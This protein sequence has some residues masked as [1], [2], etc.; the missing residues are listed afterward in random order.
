MDWKNEGKKCSRFIIIYE[1]VNWTTVKVTVLFLLFFVCF[2]YFVR[3]KRYW[4]KMNLIARRFWRMR[5]FSKFGITD[6]KLFLR[7]RFSFFFRSFF[8][9][10][11]NSDTS[12][13]RLLIIIIISIP[14]LSI[15]LPEITIQLTKKRKFLKR[16]QNTNNQDF[17]LPIRRYEKKTF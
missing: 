5:Y 4:R 7:I 8:F 9:V 12:P 14:Y 16:N 13:F 2:F 10:I 3:F 6:L 11:L 15:Y 17:R 1:P